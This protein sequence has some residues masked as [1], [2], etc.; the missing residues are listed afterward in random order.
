MVIDKRTGISPENFNQYL[1]TKTDSWQHWRNWQ[2]S[3]FLYRY[4]YIL[5]SNRIPKVL[6]MF[7]LGFYSGRKMMY[8]NPEGYVPLFNAL[9][10]WGFIIGVPAA[11]ACAYFEIFGKKI[12]DV[13]GLAHTF[14]YAIS[15]VPLSLA[16]LSAV[17]IRWI[18]K[19]GDSRLKLLA[20]V[21]RM[22][23]TNYMVQTIIGIT[24]YYG[25]G[26]NLGGNIGPAVFI[27]IG[28][29]VYAIQVVY[30]NWWFKHFNY[31]PLEWIW[32][33]LTYGK[34]LSLVKNKAGHM[35]RSRELQP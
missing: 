18:N 12:P 35:E 24:L 5:D 7:L 28:L 34:K 10:K 25:V 14:F 31:G 21:G 13:M 22:A 33:Q 32:R 19:K 20:P 4:S 17:C 11:L 1:F 2:A 9:R 6:G 27:P 15:V 29:C 16:Y 23:L 3:G 26:F 8:V 30:S